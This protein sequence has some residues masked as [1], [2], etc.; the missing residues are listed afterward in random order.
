MPFA[1]VND[2]RIHY[3][4]TGGGGL[5]VVLGHGFLMDREMFDAQEAVL[6]D[7]YRVITWDQRGHGQTVATPGP[8][9]YWDS[10][11]DL[12]GLLDALGIGRAVVGGMSQGG[13]IAMRLAL[14][15]PERVAGLILLDSQAG[16]EP[17]ENIPGYDAMVE[18]WMAQGPSDQIAETVATIIIGPHRPESAAWIAKWKAR[19]R[20]SIV[21]I[22]TTLMG[23]DDITDRL[24]EIDAPALVVHGEDDLAIGMERAEV[25]VERLPNA[26]PLVRVPGAGHA[27]NLTHSEP[28][29]AAI[30]GFLEEL[31]RS[32]SSS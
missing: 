6:R 15:H 3:V 32:L 20:E 25:L 23:R 2:Q 18:A 24:G 17:P 8:S 11:D 9:S 16:P 5:P 10:A 12:A 30:V 31:S 29:N 27:A 4:D 28:V 19:P 7:R 21:P 13:F 14:R 26:R 1:D 22:Y